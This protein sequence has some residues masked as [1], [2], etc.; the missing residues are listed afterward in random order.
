M[1]RHW[2]WILLVVVVA[3]SLAGLLFPLR[4]EFAFLRRF[5][6]K[7]TV[8]WADGTGFSS[9][10]SKPTRLFILNF[11]SPR[12]EVLKACRKQWPAMIDSSGSQDVVRFVNPS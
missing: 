5:H 8:L 7:E 11:M 4:D 10:A 1:R 9:T 6:P 12:G 3:G 2:R